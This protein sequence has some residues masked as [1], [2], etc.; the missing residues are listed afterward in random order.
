MDLR[1]PKCLVYRK[2]SPACTLFG[3]NTTVQASRDTVQTS[4]PYLGSPSFRQAGL[5]TRRGQLLRMFPPM[6]AEQTHQSLAILNTPGLDFASSEVAPPS[7]VT[8]PICDPMSVSHISDSRVPSSGPCRAPEATQGV[9]V[10][11]Q[12]AASE[13]GAE[14][15][16]TYP[17]TWRSGWTRLTSRTWGSLVGGKDT[18]HQ[19][20]VMSGHRAEKTLGNSVLSVASPAWPPLW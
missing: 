20:F 9:E 19:K 15:R 6:M 12:E 11:V 4:V 18:E 8:P 16:R 17:F 10:F 13:R 2:P 5:W 1:Y 7:C 3:S 14:G